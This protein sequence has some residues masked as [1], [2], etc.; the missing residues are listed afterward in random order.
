MGKKS[1]EKKER[2]KRREMGMEESSIK[3]E[4]ESE[5]F[6]FNAIRFVTYLVFLTPLILATEFYFP[7]VGPKSL[8]FMGG[9]QV[10][11]FIW[12]Y[13]AI[14]YKRYRPKRNS[15]LIALSLFLIVLILSSIFGVD[16]SRSFWS[17][18]ERMTGLLMWLHLLGFFLAT[19]STFK[20]SDWEKVFTVSILVSALIGLGVLLGKTDIEIFNF[21]NRGG[22]TLGNSSFLG[23]YLLFN[24]FLSLYLFFEKRDKVIKILFLTAVILGTSLMYIQGARAAF[25]STIGGFGFIFLLWFSFG[26]KSQKVKILGKILLTISIIAVL[27]AIVLLYLPNNLVHDKFGEITT[28]SRFVNWEMAQK[29]FLERPLLG[30]G[31]ENY[32]LIFPKFFNPCLF[33]PKCGGEIWFDRTHNIVLD[34]LSTTGILGFLA[35]LGLFFSSFLIL[36]KKYLKEKSIS[37]WTF[38][39]FMAMLFAYFVQNLTVFDMVT[40]LMMF[41]LVLGF[42]AFLGI[43]KKREDSKN[44][45]IPRHPWAGSLLLIIFSSTFFIFIIQPLKTDH[46]VI[47]ALM[48]N[49]SQERVDFYEKA[50]N[51]SQL[52]KY[53]I[54]GFIGHH[55]GEV[56]RINMG[57]ISMEDT[58]R[59]LDFVTGELQKTMEESPLDFR[60]ALDVSNLYNFYS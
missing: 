5:P 14:N 43:P 56:L 58:I 48:V 9:C 24:V 47:D 59:E 37:F 7:F 34:T 53:Q 17:K 55:S 51:T 26:I 1:R 54:R 6:L 41:I 28:Q 32:T 20:K 39:I 25:I 57:K 12:L 50:M 18:Y 42:I 15:I 3:P 33:T 36:G 19:S 45:Y 31:P 2:Q 46:F 4:K 38:S 22:F 60:S 10:V 29:A 27:S 23:S 44:E 52:G 21:A 16:F 30:W 35:Y 11:F 49:S 8:Y 40:S 13:L